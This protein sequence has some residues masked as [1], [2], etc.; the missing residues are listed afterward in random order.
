M[1]LDG[2]PNAPIC[3]LVFLVGRMNATITDAT[4]IIDT[5]DYTKEDVRE[6]VSDRL[7][8][9]SRNLYIIFGILGGVTLVSLGTVFYSPL[10]HLFYTAPPARIAFAD[11][12]YFQP[13]REAAFLKQAPFL[14]AVIAALEEEG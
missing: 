13:S 14:R 6:A 1:R 4:T 7:K 2:K 8:K 11:L 12:R 9:L 10:Y 3:I 5:S